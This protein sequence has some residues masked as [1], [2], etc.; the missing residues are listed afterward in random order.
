[1]TLALVH[2]RALAGVAAPPVTVEVHVANGLPAFS[3]VGLPEAEVRES[4]E[5]VRAALLTSGY[6]FP[7]RRITVNLAPAD[8]PKD[9]GR[10]DLPIAVG[11][12]AASGQL[13]TKGLDQVE[14]AGE[15]SLSGELRPVRGGL[16]MALAARDAGRALVLPA[17]SAAEGVLAPGSAVLAAG[18]LAAVCA[19]LTGQ[20]SLAPPAVAPA[21]LPAYP[22][23]ADVKGQAAARRAL[24][25]AAAGAHA[26]LLVGPPGTGKSML[27]ARLQ[28][29][30]P[31]L[32]EDEA[33]ESAAL[34]SAAGLFDPAVFGRRVQ[35]SP[36]HSAS[37]PALVGGGNDAR[38]GEISLAHA[39]VLFLDE[40]PEFDRRVLES[41]RE[42]L[43]SGRIQ[44]SR[45]GR[46]ADY[47][48]RFRLVAAMN[49]CPCG[50]RGHPQRPCRCTPDQVARYRGKLSGPLL[51]RLDLQVEVPALGAAEL[52]AAR[53]GEASATVAARVGAA[54]AR[55]L[56][57]QGCV[58]ARLE[59]EALARHAAP[60][61]AGAVLLAQA[62]ER[63]ALSPRAYHRVLRVARTIADLAGAA[64][65]Q[66]AHV[67]EALA[68]RPSA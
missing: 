44:V 52:A 27:A 24:E 53:P 32:D 41:L 67:A 12:L 54:H 30:L 35:R 3:L 60:D 28:G 62:V 13:P 26:L 38:P 15:L 49:P 51:D 9:S 21:P 7:A 14:L 2:S 46:R 33:L 31:P 29:I 36:H 56:A 23:L 66:P 22:D 5:R 57:R 17:A 68:L 4:R 11:L 18:T 34:L 63:L 8:L 45:V 58:N 47:P 37:A 10:F 16:S 64:R 43:E 42:P 39:G 20:A 1:M 6:D 25:I 19:H 61:E 59:G 50:Y 55:A 40:L 48:A 65:L